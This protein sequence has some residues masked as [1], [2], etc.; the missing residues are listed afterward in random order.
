MR[1]ADRLFQIVNLVRSHQPIT[2]E[3]LAEELNVSVRTV[4]R[5]IDDLSASNIPLYGET[6]IGYR[7][8]QGFELPPLALTADE[9]DALMLGIEMLSVSTGKE[10]T[11]AAKSLLHKIEAGLPERKAGISEPSIRAISVIDRTHTS[12]HW[13]LLR[14]AIQMRKVIQF[15]YSTLGGISSDRTAYPLGLFYWGGKWTLG[16]WCTLR[17]AFREF[18]IDRIAELEIT[19]DTFQSTGEINL[20]AYM[21]H[22]SSNWALQNKIKNTDNTLSVTP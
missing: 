7:L 5:Y 2:A 22:Q 4:Y 21:L 6:G 13:D 8:H 11:H 18:R 20:K 19:N 17:S 14:G 9:Y 16:T 12:R 1:K 15:S 3:R 10:L